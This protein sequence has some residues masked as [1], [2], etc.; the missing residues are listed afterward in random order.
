MQSNIAISVK[1]LSK[2]YPLRQIQT[3]E[4]GNPINEFWALKGVS[5][6]IKK[7]DSI[8]I[9]GQNGS[10]KST[11]LRILAGATKPTSGNVEIK[12][13]VASILDIGA[14]FHT[15]L[16]GRENVFMSGQSLLGCSKKEI[17]NVFDEIVA[18]SGIG[19]FIDEPIKHYSSG[20]YLRLAFSIMA[21]LDFDVYLF[22]E[23]LGVGD[24]AFREK[25][26]E[27]IQQLSHQQ[28]TFLLISHNM[29]EI[30]KICNSAYLLKNGVISNA[31]TIDEA[32]LKYNNISQKNEV[33]FPEFVKQASVTLTNEM[34]QKNEYFSNEEAIFISIHNVFSTLSKD[35]KIGIR[36]SDRLNNAVFNLSPILTKDGIIDIDFS[37]NQFSTEIPAYTLNAG[38]Y[39]VDLVYFDN[40]NVINEIKNINYFKI[41]L[42]ERF[43]TGNMLGE[44]GVLMP[45]YTWEIK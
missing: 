3:D 34:G 35:I 40:E 5:F 8:G 17:E 2:K 45:F 37:K 10:G 21:H 6:E 18:F 1:N 43:M 9:I 14:G 44:D 25:C 23:V 39:T 19:E 26:L 4:I 32:L 20:M 36:L 13:N 28:K 33:I 7:G 42:A 24:A 41:K 12:G 16:S 38:F 22:D 11:L 29:G 27:K 15:E 30:A 31:L